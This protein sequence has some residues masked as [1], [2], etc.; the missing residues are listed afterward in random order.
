MNL[1]TCPVL[2]TPLAATDYA[3]AV[4]QVKEW[5]LA[6]DGPRLV[7]AANTHVV[8][9]AR[10]ESAF[11][12]ALGEFDLILPDGMP[13]VWTMNRRLA[14]PLR[15]RVYGPTFMLY[16]LEATQ[17]EP[18]RHLFIGGTDELLAALGG[19]LLAQFPRLQIAGSYAPPFGEWGPGEDAKTIERI[20]K[21]GA[22]FVWIGLGCPK[23]ERWLARHKAALPSAVY[24]AVGAA[25]AFHAGRVAQAPLW[26]QG[27]GLEWLFRLA[28]EPRRL[29]RRYFVY[30]SLFVFYS[31]RDA[32]AGRRG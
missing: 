30:N 21:A 22:Q 29:W 23:Q 31:V 5:A 1:A 28:A 25:F 2:G 26:V 15:D 17:G 24:S 4:A 16:C 11:A 3:G 14:A 10:H 8:T 19:K 20:R 32:L 6:A 12:R 27:V 13:L 7:A 9:L 18:W